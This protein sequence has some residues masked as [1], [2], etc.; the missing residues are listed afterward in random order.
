MR[1]RELA[2]SFHPQAKG[3]SRRKRTLEF[4]SPDAECIPNGGTRYTKGA[5][6]QQ[7]R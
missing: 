4:K 7:S 1:L 3:P 5:E 2:A 6:A